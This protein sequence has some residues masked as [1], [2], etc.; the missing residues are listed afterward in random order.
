[1]KFAKEWL[2]DD[3]G[4]TVET[5]MTDRSRWSIHYERVFKHEG[6]F[7][8]T[9]YSVGATESQDERPYEYE[10]DEIECVEVFPMQKLVTVYVA[11]GEAA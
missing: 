11:D 8:R 4:E 5:K 2:Q 7:Y 9:R 10:P 6:R 1:M 3:G